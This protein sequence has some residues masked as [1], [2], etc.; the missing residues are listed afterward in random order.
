[1]RLRMKEIR[2]W[3]LPS[4]DTRH[5][6]AGIKGSHDIIPTN[7]YIVHIKGKYSTRHPI[8][9][10]CPHGTHITVTHSY[11]LRGC[12]NCQAPHC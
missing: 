7:F 9:R 10:Q 2:S 3:V 11:T 1:M 6:V 12:R 4:W 5:H 8:L